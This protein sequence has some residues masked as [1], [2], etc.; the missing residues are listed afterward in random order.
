M[1]LFHQLCLKHKADKIPEFGHDYD[2]VY[3]RI[4]DRFKDKD[5]INI[6]EV[7]TGC[8]KVMEPL[9]PKYV[10][11]AFGRVL[12]DYFGVERISFD[13]ID[14]A[15]QQVA[16]K[17]HPEGCFMMRNAYSMATVEYLR[18]RAPYDLIIEDGSH[19]Y[20]DQLFVIQ[21]YLELLD[22]EGVLVVEDVLVGNLRHLADKATRMN[23]SHSW[24]SRTGHP[25][26]N[27][28]IVHNAGMDLPP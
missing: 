10:Q 2:Q 20:D 25:D 22:S 19:L 28:F 15:D 14:V 26:N 4:L 24:P 8:R 5:R 6:L 23:Q 13:S 1:D 7:G 27:L 18:P 12:R 11:G 16:R 21:H 17:N 3:P 9:I